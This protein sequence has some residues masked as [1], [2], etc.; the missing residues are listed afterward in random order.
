LFLASFESNN[1]QATPK[2]NKR[3]VK[4]PTG[5]AIFAISAKNRV[6]EING[7]QK[8]LYFAISHITEII[9]GPLFRPFLRND[10]SVLYS[11]LWF[12]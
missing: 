11:Y 6:T 10:L 7:N 8:F 9:L 3:V 4:G 1:D 5:V 2:T 12:I